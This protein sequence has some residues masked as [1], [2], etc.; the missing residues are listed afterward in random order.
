MGAAPPLLE[1]FRGVHFGVVFGT[2]LGRFRTGFGGGRVRLAVISKMILD[3]FWM[4]SD[5]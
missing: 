2:I 3:G 1:K 4:L 5:P